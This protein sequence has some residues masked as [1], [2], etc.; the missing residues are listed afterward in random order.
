[1]SPINY[2]VIL[3][4]SQKENKDDLSLT[5]KGIDLEKPIPIPSLIVMELKK[6]SEKNSDIV[7]FQN[8]EEVIKI[9]SGPSLSGFNYYYIILFTKA[10]QGEKS[11]YLIG[12]VKKQGD[13]LLGTW[14]FNGQVTDLSLKKIQGIFNHLI[15]KSEEYN[16]ISLI[17]ASK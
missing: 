14:P 10:K 1:M 17:T 12:N 6:L 11:G 7:A 3:K 13:I 2:K 8:I 9:G 16:D 5:F 4:G 15:Q